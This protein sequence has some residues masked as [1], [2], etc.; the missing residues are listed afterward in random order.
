MN[1]YFEQ[2]RITADEVHTVLKKISA[3][4]RKNGFS[5][6]RFTPRKKT[7]LRVT[8]QVDRGFFLLDAPIDNGRNCHSN[9]SHSVWKL[10][11]LNSITPGGI[12]FAIY[13]GSRSIRLRSEIPLVEDKEI[14]SH[15]ILD[16]CAG[17][18]KA[19][20][21]CSRRADPGKR[22]AADR[23]PA[24]VDLPGL[25]VEAGWVS[26][27]RSGLEIVRLDV[28]DAFYE[29]TLGDE[30]GRG[31][32]ASTPLAT[33]S[34]WPGECRVA[35]GVLLLS[36]SG[37]MR[38]VRASAESTAQSRTAVQFEAVLRASPS[39]SELDYGLSALSVACR[40]FGKEVRALLDRNVANSYL[41]TRGWSA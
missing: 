26:S 32:V 3:K 30:D 8:A 36:V 23:E 41:E 29:A 1:L 12:K 35:L 31:L 16:A 4:I 40:M 15:R 6:W 2:G 13:G 39:G 34:G 9:T 17:F 20:E 33:G 25:C 28:P 14:L 5:T 18:E 22:A 11:Q 27:S 24:G 7:S 10:L 38:M 37:H 19:L 21:L